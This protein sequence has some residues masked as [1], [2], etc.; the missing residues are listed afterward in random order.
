MAMMPE[1]AK[2]PVCMDLLGYY[3]SRKE[4]WEHLVPSADALSVCVFMLF[5]P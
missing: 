3:Q 4:L 5:Y 1:C 2:V